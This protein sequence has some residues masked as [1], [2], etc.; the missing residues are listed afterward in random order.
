MTKTGSAKLY[1]NGI[2]NHNECSAWLGVLDI[3]GKRYLVTGFVEIFSPSDAALFLEIHERRSGVRTS[4]KSKLEVFH[5]RTEESEPHLFGIT[6]IHQ[7]RF[8]VGCWMCRDTKG[9]RYFLLTFSLI[10]EQRQVQ[11]VIRRRPRIKPVRLK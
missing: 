6:I 1:P 8:A 9:K 3:C 7:Q 4:Q 2:P 10:E 5:N 11:P